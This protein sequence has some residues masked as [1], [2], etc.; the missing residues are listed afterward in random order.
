MGKKEQ[1]RLETATLQRA[2]Q[3][4]TK[5]GCFHRA[6]AEKT[7]TECGR[8]EAK[9]TV[10]HSPAAQLLRQGLDSLGWALPPNSPHRLSESLDRRQGQRTH[11]QGWLG[12]SSMPLM[13]GLPRALT[14]SHRASEAAD[15]LY[16]LRAGAVEQW[17]CLDRIK[18]KKRNERTK[19]LGH[20]RGIQEMFGYWFKSNDWGFYQHF[21]PIFSPTRQNKFF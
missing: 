17:K 7:M 6:R 19:T 5:H 1:S 3:T 8:A 11:F 21:M 20:E 16:Y 9:G 12:H 13:G 4:Q 2:T 14:Q 10:S 15:T 18:K